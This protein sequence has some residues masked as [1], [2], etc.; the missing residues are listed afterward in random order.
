[1]LCLRQHKKLTIYLF[2]QKSLDV[3]KTGVSVQKE[4]KNELYDIYGTFF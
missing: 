2:I 1:M 4:K 3:F